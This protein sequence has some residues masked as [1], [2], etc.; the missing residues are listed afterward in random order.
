MIK[1][2]ETVI[3]YKYKNTEFYWILIYYCVMRDVYK[4]KLIIIVIVVF[5]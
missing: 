1:Y 5:I 3:E 4:L 2:G